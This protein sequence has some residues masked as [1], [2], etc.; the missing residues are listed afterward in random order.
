MRTFQDRKLISMVLKLCKSNLQIL[1]PISDHDT[2]DTVLVC[3]L[4]LSNVQVKILILGMSE[5]LGNIYF[6]SIAIVFEIVFFSTFR[7]YGNLFFDKTFCKILNLCFFY[8]KN[9]R[10][11]SRKTTQR[12]LVVES[13]PTPLLSKVFKLLSISLRYTLSFEW[14]GFGLKYLVTVMPEG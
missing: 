7:H 3:K 6:R 10:T 14:P 11:G 4:Y 9:S 12:W 13:C 1:H 8:P 2:I 5:L